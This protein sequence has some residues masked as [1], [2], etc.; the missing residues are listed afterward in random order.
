MDDK[1]MKALQKRMTTAPRGD[2]EK[3][4]GSTKSETM[5]RF[6]ALLESET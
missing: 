5:R 6:S 4:L 1:K 2:D 3:R